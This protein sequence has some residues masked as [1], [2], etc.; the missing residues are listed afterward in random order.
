[1]RSLLNKIDEVA[2]LLHDCDIDVLCV[3]E[4]WLNDDVLDTEVSI[5]GY[6]HYRCDRLQRG[7]GGYPRSAP[8]YISTIYNPPHSRNFVDEFQSYLMHFEQTEHIILGDF[9]IN[10]AIQAASKHFTS[11]LRAFGPYNVEQLE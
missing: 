9:N 8:F 5:A 1:M 3:T 4:S 10:M 11:T 7:G 2:N 6:K